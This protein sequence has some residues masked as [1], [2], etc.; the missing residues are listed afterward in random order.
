MPPQPAPALN[1]PAL[2]LTMGLISSVVGAWIWVVLRLAFGKPVLPPST[3]RVVPWGPG[4]VLLA[5]LAWVAAMIAAP[6]AYRVAFPG[7][8]AGRA[9]GAMPDPGLLMS[10]SAAQNLAT[11][12]LVP[13]IL[14]ITAGARRR[15]YG[16]G[17]S[18]LGWQAV[19]GIVAYPIL[20]PLVFGVMLASI[21]VFGRTTH[22]LEEAIQGD[23]TPGMAAILIL[24]GVVLAPAAEELI[25]RGVLLGWLTRVALGVKGLATAR[26]PADDEIRY[27]S[28]FEPIAS[29][30]VGSESSPIA[31]EVLPIN[32]Y[33]PPTAPTGPPP[34]AFEIVYEDGTA[35]GTPAGRALPMLL[36]NVAVSLIFAAMHGAVW[37]T[38]IPIFF[39]SMG[40]GVLYQR[41]GG[42]IAPVALHVTFNG[43][44]TLLMFLAVGAD[45]PQAPR[46]ADPN[47]GPAWSAPAGPD[48][49]EFS[50]IPGP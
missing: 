15:D 23:R 47:P 30:A 26:P 48:R 3:P 24:A 35:A 39:L 10:L 1:V 14:A 29:P 2:L 5:M 9:G 21:K 8:F 6:L 36:A 43:I 20:A 17:W 12:I 40:L 22:P 37:P 38:P 16:V 7:H 44:S 32:P 42:I 28:T 46:P 45:P 13:A 25:F 18:G 50:P 33:S 4:S 11:L 49:P 41:T 19:R 27:I 34:P 31:G